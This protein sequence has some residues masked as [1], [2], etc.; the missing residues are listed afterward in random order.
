VKRAGHNKGA[1]GSPVYMAPEVLSDKPYDEKADV[2]S[3]GVVLWELVTGGIPYQEEG[4]SALDEI[5]K[6]VVVDNIRPKIPEQTPPTLAKLIRKCW[7]ANPSKRPSFA[8]VLKKHVLD[9]V[10]VDAIISPSNAIARTFWKENFSSHDEVHETV[11]W[12][13]FIAAMVKFCNIEFN[14]G[15]PLDDQLE[16]KALKLI[17]V[18]NRDDLVTIEKFSKA[19]EWFGPFSKDRTFADQ[20]TEI[21][22]LPGFFGDVASK[23]AEQSMAG[24]KPGTYMI[25]FSSQ[26]PGFY[27][28]TTMGDDNQLKHYR[29]KHKAGLGYVLG[30]KEYPTLAALIKTHRRDL[31]LKHAIKDSKYATLI[32]AHETDVGGAYSE[33]L[34]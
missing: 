1:T 12:K 28:I 22:R 32:I 13:K 33:L 27:T 20:I 24:K 10:I 7:D 31:Y 5:F 14:N 3:Y 23:E 2:Y 21:I 34:V 11:S 26:Q 18:D 17:L 25:R 8:A 30:D 29:I 16:V 6:H 9:D 15:K 4:F 19:L